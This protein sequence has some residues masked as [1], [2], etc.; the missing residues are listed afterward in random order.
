MPEDSLRSPSTAGKLELPRFFEFGGFR[1]D[2]ERRRLTRNGEPV[3]V[4][5]KTLELLLALVRRHGEVV[6]KDELMAS[7][8]QGSVVEENS[9]NVHVS[10]LRKLFGETPNEHRFIVTV[11]G[12]GYR[13]V[14]PVR[15]VFTA[16]ETIDAN[17]NQEGLA[18]LDAPKTKR[19]SK[20]LWPTIAMAFLAI[21]VLTVWLV[22]KRSSIR[23]DPAIS[24]V[25]Q[26][27][28]WS[29]LDFYPSI[30]PD[31]NAMA[32]SS[33]RTGSFEI[34]FRQLVPGA[35]EVQLTSG[36]QNFEPAFS[37]DG[38]LVAFYSRQR[39]GIWIVPTSGGAAKQLTNFGSHPAWSPDGSRI[40]FQSD[41]LFDLGFNVSNAFPPSTI[42]TIAVDHGEPSQITHAGNPLGGHG[43]PSWSPDGRRIAFDAS[44]TA[45]ESVWSVSAD[46]KDVK[47]LSGDLRNA[48]DVIYAPDG[49]SVYFVTDRGESIQQLNLSQTGEPAGSPRKLLDASGSRIRQLSVSADGKHLVYSALSTSSDLWSNQ[50]SVTGAGVSNPPVPLTQNKNT[51]NS[52]PAFSPDGKRI[53]Y[54]VYSVGASFEVWIMDRDGSNRSQL[55]TDTANP[56]WFPDGKHIG[57]AC[58]SGNRWAFCSLAIDGRKQ[59]ELLNF[60]DFVHVTR[61]SPDGKQ[62]A[63]NVTRGETTNIWLASTESGA[64]RQL[65]F[66]RELA[67][68]PVWSPDGKWIAFEVKRGD[69]D[70]VCIVPSG[71]GEVI[72]LTNDKG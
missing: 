40:A 23:I 4:M 42:W 72:Q 44:D 67:G 18:A 57:F 63:F 19:K 45:I 54:M 22:S 35:R 24:R 60:D 29:G 53:A 1:L 62:V 49:R 5:P 11:P 61:L 56:T 33:D 3:Q 47:K 36:G 70:H 13:F 30:S 8:W 12:Q 58:R 64:L 38:T 17:A 27:T 68:F 37:P 2:V 7:V 9:L 39:R 10:A 21:I 14:A 52:W 65:T 55:S 71:G 66:D 6:A 69:D 59:V 20:W 26:L 46:G 51:R 28:T 31:G 32:F 34:Y 50:I 41:P 16:E 15:D 43:A 48:A 25:A